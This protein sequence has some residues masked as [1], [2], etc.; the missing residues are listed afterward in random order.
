MPACRS[1]ARPTIISATSKA[2]VERDLSGTVKL[3]YRFSPELLTYISYARGYKAGG[4]NLD[5][6][7]CPNAPGCAARLIGTRYSNTGFAARISPT[8]MRSGSNRP[9]STARCFS[10]PRLFFQH[11]RNFQLNTF[12]GLVFVVDS[13]PDVYSRGV[14]ADFVW[15]PTANLSFQGGITSRRHANSPTGISRA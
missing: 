6:V 10:T 8:P 1:K 13:V 11:F 12:N 14:D 9:C 7:S 5:R 2:T 4:F 15:L 3:A